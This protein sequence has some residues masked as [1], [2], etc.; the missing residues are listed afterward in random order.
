M[1]CRDD[2]IAMCRMVSSVGGECGVYGGRRM[3]GGRN[4]VG[5][6]RARL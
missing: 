2:G 6:R 4:G 5:G 1:C 3:G